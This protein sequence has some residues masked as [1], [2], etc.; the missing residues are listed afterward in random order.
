MAFRVG[1]NIRTDGIS[2]ALAKLTKHMKDRRPILEAMGLE[3]VSITQRAFSDEGLRPKAWPPRKGT[4]VEMRRNKIGREIKVVVNTKGVME[5]PL[6]IKSGT[7]RRSIEIKRLTGDL[8]M[9]GTDR[10]YAAVQQFGSRKKSGRGS[11]IPARPFFPFIGIGRMTDFAKRRIVEV[12]WRKARL[13]LK[14]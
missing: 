12:A 2:P 6:L 11:G 3:L 7:M 8:V 10:A 5:H 9:V 4:R 1:F 14:P 13:M